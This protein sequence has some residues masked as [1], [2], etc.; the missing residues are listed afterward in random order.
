MRQIGSRASAARDRWVGSRCS[1]FVVLTIGGNGGLLGRLG[2]PKFPCLPLLGAKT[3][4]FGEPCRNMTTSKAAYT[5]DSLAY[6]RRRV[7]DHHLAITYYRQAHALYRSE[8][9]RS[10]EAE[11][12]SA[13]T[14]SAPTPVTP[15]PPAPRGNKH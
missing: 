2:I 6:L 11:S 10:S 4:M 12:S 7:G 15:T 13:S 14:T 3:T 1:A 8:G 9:E 5:L